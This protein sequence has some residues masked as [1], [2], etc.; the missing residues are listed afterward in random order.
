MATYASVVELR[1]QI[2]KTGTGDDDELALLLDAASQAI[3]NHC[4][5]P[6]GF[7]ADVSASARVYTGS[8]GPFQFID[9]C[10]SI[11]T[12]AV[13]DSP[14]DST[15]TSWSSSDWTG[16]AGDPN[17]PEFQPTVKQKPYTAVMI[18]AGGS[19]SHFTSGKYTSRRG[20]RPSFYVARG[21][22][23]VQVTA[24]WGYAAEVPDAIKQACLT[25]A[26]RWYKRGQSAWADA[27][28]N[29]EL[30]QLMYTKKLDPAIQHILEN[31]RYVRPVI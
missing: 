17:N 4:N 16:F 8:G 29:P 19:Y 11:S 20:F 27:V 7:I 5:R 3:D 26:A 30:G 1:N 28:G 12:V 9:E 13:K 2:N 10:V 6:D 21:V 15:Y 23:T 31:G 18:A 25:Q 22:P 14:T 24:R